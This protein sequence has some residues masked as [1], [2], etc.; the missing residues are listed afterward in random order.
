MLRGN[1]AE[2]PLVGILQL[3]S[4]DHKTGT[5]RILENHAG[6]IGVQHGRIVDAMYHPSRGERALSLLNSLPSAPF[7]FD[8]SAAPTETTITGRTETLLLELHDEHRRWLKLRERLKDWSLDPQWLARPE[9]FRTAEQ[10]LI[11][12]LIDGKRPI[13][14]LLHDSSLSPLRTA[15]VLVDMANLR[16][17]ALS[18]ISQL[19]EPQTLVVLSV[20]HPDDTTVFVDRALYRVW[21][22]TFGKVRAV[23][24]PVKGEREDFKVQPR[25]GIGERIMIPDAALRKLKLARG[26]KVTVVPRGDL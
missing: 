6:A 15:E 17:I 24:I 13:D 21:A 1:L 16:L 22:E 20:Y 14:R 9:K 8:S 7:Q 3:I 10:A 11:A 18:P 4:S 25:D 23:V 12:E 26:V 2:F 5:V 19:T